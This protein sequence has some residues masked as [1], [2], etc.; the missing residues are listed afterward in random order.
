MIQR[1]PISTRTDTLFPYTTRFRSR[2][3]RGACGRD[4]RRISLRYALA[5]VRA[6]KL[7]ASPQGA[8]KL[9]AAVPHIAIG[10]AIE[11]ARIDGKTTGRACRICPA[12]HTASRSPAAQGKR[13]LLIAFRGGVPVQCQDEGGCVSIGSDHLR[14]PEMLP[15]HDRSDG[16]STEP[17][18]CPSRQERRFGRICRKAFC[19]GRRK[20]GDKRYPRLSL[21]AR[22]TKSCRCAPPSFPAEEQ[23]RAHRSHLVQAAAPIRHDPVGMVMGGV[24]DGTEY[25]S[26]LQSLMR[27]SYAV[28]C[29]NKTNSANHQ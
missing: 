24:S 7:F 12:K 2:R 26:E 28:F 29:W 19:M 11:Q 3:G 21:C 8:L 20:T 16:C 22:R 5:S 23:V 9:G 15:S 17:F 1:P 27:L 14:R 13:L 10:H 6:R 4:F 25:R 18:K